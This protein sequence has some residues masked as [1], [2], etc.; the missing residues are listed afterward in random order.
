MV[1][2]AYRHRIIKGTVQGTYL[3]DIQKSFVMMYNKTVICPA[4][5]R[6][7]FAG[8]VLDRCTD[9]IYPMVLKTTPERRV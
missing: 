4:D 3:R 1:I 2:D 5:F 8:A 9:K 6:T 7:L